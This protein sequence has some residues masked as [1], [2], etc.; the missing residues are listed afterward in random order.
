VRIISG[1]LCLLVAATALSLVPA[2][3]AQ[4]LP[5]P[6]LPQPA[7]RDLGT[8][9]GNTSRAIAVNDTGQVVGLSTVDAG[10]LILHVF[11]WQNGVMTDIGDSFD[12][13]D[14][15][16]NGSVAVNIHQDGGGTRAGIWR[17]GTVTDLGL[18][19]ESST[20]TAINNR[21]EVVGTVRKGDVSRAFVWR[22][23]VVTDLGGEYGYG[24]ALDI[25]DNGVVAGTVGGTDPYLHAVLWRDGTIVHLGE[26]MG[27]ARAIND[28]DEVAVGGVPPAFGVPPVPYLWKDGVATE[29]PTLGP[30][31]TELNGIN[32]R[33]EIVGT[34]TA[35]DAVHAA[36]WLDG[37]IKD[38]G[39]WTANDINNR[40]QIVGVQWTSVT[41]PYYR[42]VLLG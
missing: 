29:L 42:A 23:G 22:G 19:G 38:L 21:D 39:G 18:G 28:R 33:G 10:D 35:P 3:P 17:N 2:V 26:K 6:A 24:E 7:P 36:R 15:S 16:N 1:R 8:L 20:A 25:N 34:S 30:G 5:Q 27:V 31:F 9:G 12:P 37:R 4:A 40:G 32:N 41:P 11:L 13:V 14:I